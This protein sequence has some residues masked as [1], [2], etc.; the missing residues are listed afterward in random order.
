M[1]MLMIPNGA[2][3][4]GIEVVGDTEVEDG[5]VVI[6]VGVDGLVK[7]LLIRILLYE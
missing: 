1:L 6:G 7:E 2:V 4:D 5:E 3:E